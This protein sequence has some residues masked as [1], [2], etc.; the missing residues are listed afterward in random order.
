MRVRIKEVH[1]EDGFYDRLDIVGMTGDFE[2]E[3]TNEFEEYPVGFSRGR[4]VAE[5]DEPPAWRE[6]FFHAIKVE[7]C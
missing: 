2:P 4:F 3:N 6:Y 1:W 7:P 5:G